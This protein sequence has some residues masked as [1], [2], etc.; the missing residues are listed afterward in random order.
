MHSPNRSLAHFS[1]YLWL[2]LGAFLLCV[3]SF[4]FYIQ[5]ETAARE[6]DE[7]RL[8]SLLLAHEL[9]QSSD[10]LTRMVR[11]YIA[12]SNPVY[13]RHY[14]EILEIRD[15]S[16]PRPLGYEGVYW[17]LVLDDKRPTPMG[18]RAPLLE[19][20]QAAGFSPEEFDKLAEAK[21]HSDALVA[22]E[23][24]AMK[25]IAVPAGDLSTQT[26]AQYAQAADMN[27]PAAIRMLHDAAYPRAKADIMKPIGEFHRM[28]SER[29]RIMVDQAQ[30]RA[31]HMLAAFLLFGTALVLLLWR[32][33]TSLRQLM[34]AP[35]NEL[36]KIVSQATA[37]D[38]SLSPQL[39]QAPEDTLL[40]KVAQVELNRIEA[41]G[42]HKD[43][44]RA[45]FE[46]EQRF[47]GVVAGASEGICIIQDA[48][49]CLANPALL[50]IMGYNENELI[51]HPFIELVV[52]EDRPALI[53]RSRQRIGKLPDESHFPFR[54]C[55]RSG[56]F[57]W[58]EPKASTIEW[59][60]RQATMYFLKVI[61]EP[62]KQD[63][64][65]DQHA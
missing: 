2:T 50:A 47:R 5:A 15:G 62:I 56:G 55:T 1:A 39:E 40:G 23:R 17:D 19:R 63:E 61:S 21:A 45:F 26:I 29:T 52:P 11:T 59:A 6:A 3:I 53:A 46:S 13:K 10:D 34:G 12:T 44:E 8:R 18:D 25:L 64:L 51:D 36:H 58:V 60:G 37:G 27:R 49:I 41:V 20:M 38:M 43:A 30:S 7:V 48:V 16:K 22:I 33:R 4:F 31:R 28:A 35:I 24:E 54:I 57:C 9:R 65:L 42:K 14:D 32:L